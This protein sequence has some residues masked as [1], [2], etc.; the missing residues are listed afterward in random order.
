MHSY[1]CILLCVLVHS[2]MGVP[3]FNVDL[4]RLLAYVYNISTSSL[5]LTASTTNPPLKISFFFSFFFY[6]KLPLVR[7]FQR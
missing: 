4:T 3:S 5:T 6:H 1:S 2:D 7:T